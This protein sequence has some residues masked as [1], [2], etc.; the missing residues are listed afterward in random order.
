[1]ALPFEALLLLLRSPSLLLLSIF[2]GIFTLLVSGGSVYFLWNFFLTSLSLWISIPTA[3]F[4][5]LLL[6]L[7][8]GNL[9]LLPVEDIIVDKVQKSFLGAV[10][11]PAKPFSLR[12]IFRELVF[13]IFV[14]GA[15]IIFLLLSLIPGIAVFSFI[16]GAWISAY[17]FLST[18]YTRATETPQERIRI[19]FRK[20]IAHM[21]LG[22]FL[23]ML[24]FVP[25]LNVFLLG[26]ALILATLFG[27]KHGANTIH[28]SIN[29]NQSGH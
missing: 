23:N 26:Y 4:V 20:P 11:V 29:D 24:L 6:W 8:Y 28:T 21:F 12:R 15:T 18:F 25:I 1:M 16:A 17:G 22:L 13:S 19:F 2:P 7:I 10:K 27:M 9:A 3:A 14:M 5:F